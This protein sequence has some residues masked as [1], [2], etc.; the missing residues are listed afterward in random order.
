MKLFIKLAWRNIWRNW[1]RSLL[2]ILA[3]FFAVFLSIIMRSMQL[4]TYEV[5]IATVINMF[6]SHIQIQ[7]K[8]FLENP[9]LRN[10]FELDKINTNKLDKND[11]IIA[12]TPRISG[13]GLVSFENNTFGAILYGINPETESEVTT[14]N[15]RVN[16][17][18]FVNSNNIYDIVV[19]HKM[20]EN[21]NAEVGDTVVILSSAFDGSMGNLKFRI[22]GTSKMGMPEFD[23]MCVFM[24]I[25]A[26]KE[27][28][29][30]GNR[31]STIAIKTKNLNNLDQVKSELTQIINNKNISVLKWD[32]VMPE[33]KQSIEFD[34]I[35][36]LLFVIIL[37]LVVAFGILN[38]ILMSVTERFREFGI[39]LALG[40]KQAKLLIIVLI[41]TIFLSLIGIFAGNLTSLGAIIYF[42]DNP[43]YYSAELGEMI[44]QYGFLPA[45][46][47][48]SDPMIFIN[49]T[50]IV[51]FVSLT[52]FIYPGYRLYKLE[53]LKGI[54]YT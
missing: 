47:F 9:T 13:N 3:V 40:M 53:A 35:S 32:E 46:F 19:G 50:F 8:K 30:M 28:L 45:L 2:T 23:K 16:S 5:N 1:R 4:G 21:L 11:N 38:T 54:R 18:K 29:F 52:V 17:G 37:V 26:A 34:N 41:E 44:E 31:V 14:F 20:L 10:T 43:I 51:L 12:W 27:L 33:F 15:K 6:V 39:M 22:S 24:H 48:T 7:N 25:D 36:G 49:Y 42:K